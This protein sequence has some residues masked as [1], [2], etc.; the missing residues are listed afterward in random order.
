MGGWD[1]GKKE[2]KSQ[3]ISN[4]LLEVDTRKVGKKVA[5]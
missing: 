1:A 4:G 2:I 5:R 3:H